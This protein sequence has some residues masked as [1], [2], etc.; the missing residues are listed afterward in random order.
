[1]SVAQKKHTF[2]LIKARHS[3]VKA[4]VTATIRVYTLYNIQNCSYRGGYNPKNNT[5]LEMR[6][7][8]VGQ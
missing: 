5:D 8:K 2:A 1:M 7:I 3:I 6:R 4:A